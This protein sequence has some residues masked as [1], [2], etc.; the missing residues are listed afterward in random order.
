MKKQV[1]YVIFRVFLC[2]LN[3][4]LCL[5]ERFLMNILAIFLSFS[6]CFDVIF[7]GNNLLFAEKCCIFAEL[8]R[9]FNFKSIFYERDYTFE[10]NYDPGAL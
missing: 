9:W 3:D 4:F 10:R 6:M 2:F 7:S 5:F 1:F 8:K